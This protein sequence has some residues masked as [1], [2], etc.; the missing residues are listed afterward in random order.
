MV[1]VT[2]PA[3]AQRA[4]APFTGNLVPQ[5]SPLPHIESEQRPETAP[6]TGLREPVGPAAVPH[7]SVTICSVTIIGATA[8]PDARLQPFL[9]GLV[10]PATTLAAIEQVRTALVSLYRRH[11]YVLSTVNAEIGVDGALRFNVVEGHVVDA[12]L[13]GDIGP[14][15]VQVLRFLRHLTEEQPLDNATLERWL[16]L[17]QDVPG[18]TLHAVLRPSADDPGALTLVAQVS[19][20]AVNGLATVDNRAFAQTGPQQGLVAVDLNSV[21]Q[22]GERTEATFYHTS[23]NTQNFG[24]ISTDAFVGGSVLHV[25]LYAGYGK[26]TPSDYLR[27]IQYEGFTD[28]FGGSATYPLIRSRQQT[29]NLS[30][31]LDVVETEIRTASGP[32]AAVVRASRDSFRVGR[33]GAA[34]ALEDVLLGGTRPASNF[35]SPRVS[36]GLPF[37]GG[38]GSDNPLPSRAG[39]HAR[40]D[41]PRLLPRGQ[42][43]LAARGRTVAHPLRT[44]GV[45]A[46]HCITRRLA[47]HGAQPCRLGPVLAVQHMRDRVEPRRRPGPH[48]AP[49]QRPQLGR[50][51][52]RQDPQA[53]HQVLP[54]VGPRSNYPPTPPP[55]H[56]RVNASAQ[57]YYSCSFRVERTLLSR[58]Q[59]SAG[60][61]PMWSVYRVGVERGSETP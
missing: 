33:A 35:V 39:E 44:V 28:T 45:V 47:V 5:G 50:T 51:H 17:A 6:D 19:R 9:I 21:T 58:K 48:V 30:V 38:E 32:E 31:N 7:A 16:L 14:A 18:V 12:K 23:G 41:Q 57:R 2:G 59:R 20:Q 40:C 8:F 15:G 55:T 43:R 49:R 54:T 36:Q 61:A 24:Q 11:G 26:A 1:A 10:G 22:L 37:L 60:T 29:L 42:P 52:I 56:K 3:L 53:S 34:Y 25:R 13:D 27:T 4:G 46:H